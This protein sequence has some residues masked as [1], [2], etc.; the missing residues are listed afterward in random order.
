MKMLCHRGLWLSPGEKNSP[1]ALQ[2]AIARGFGLETDVRDCDGD[3]MISHDAPRRATADGLEAFL[4]F[5]AAQAARPLLALNIKSDGLQASLAQALARHQIRNYFVFD[6]SVPDTL[7]YRRAGMPFAVRLSEYEPANALL[8]DAAFVWLDAFDGEWYSTELI[9]QLLRRG[10]QVAVVSP[11]LHRRPHQAL[12]SQLKSLEMSP[13]L[14]L[15]TDF[16]DEA[17]E[18]F[19]VESN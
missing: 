15:C 8:D 3:L 6:M 4:Q 1:Q 16:F 12:W 7:A 13:Q 9:E 19:H 17:L 18:V 14:H 10:K 11:E 2:A 5:Y